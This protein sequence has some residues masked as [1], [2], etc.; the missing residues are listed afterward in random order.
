[1]KAKLGDKNTKYNEV[2][3]ERHIGTSGQEV[4][5][6]GVLGTRILA[7]DKTRNAEL[8]HKNESEFCQR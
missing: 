7:N 1:M 5:Y 2:N 6:Y 4:P 8:S 3:K